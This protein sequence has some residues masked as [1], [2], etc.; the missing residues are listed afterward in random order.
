MLTETRSATPRR[1]VSDGV[2]EPV[3]VPQLADS[4]PVAWSD[5]AAQSPAQGMVAWLAGGGSSTPRSTTPADGGS[6]VEHNDDAD[7]L[8]NTSSLGMESLRAMKCV[9]NRLLRSVPEHQEIDTSCLPQSD[10][11]A[12]AAHMID[13]V[14]ESVNKLNEAPEQDTCLLL[15]CLGRNGVCGCLIIRN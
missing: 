2:S 13:E 6:T 9:S 3:D 12:M 14:I 1:H 4:A 11:L 8:S 15:L 5:T 10:Q 7:N